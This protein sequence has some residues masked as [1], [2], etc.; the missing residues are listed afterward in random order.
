MNIIEL[1]SLCSLKMYL[2]KHSAIKIVLIDFIGIIYRIFIRRSTTTMIF[3][4][5]LLLGRSTIKLIKILCYFYIKTDNS[6]STP[7][8]FFIRSLSTN[9]RS[10]CLDIF[11]Y[12]VIYYRL[13]IRLLYY[14]ICLYTARMSYYKRVIYKFKYLKL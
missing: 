6:Q 4:N 5:P 8:F 11:L 2:T 3:I 1:G 13:V 14:L 10:V 9:V 12:I 7:Y